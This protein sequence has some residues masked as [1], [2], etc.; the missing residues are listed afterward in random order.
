MDTTLKSLEKYLVSASR[1]KKKTGFQ[2]APTRED[3]EKA[4]DEYLSQ[5]GKIKI[6]EPEWIEEGGFI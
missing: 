3:I 4:L 6:I 1:R 2:A 5:G